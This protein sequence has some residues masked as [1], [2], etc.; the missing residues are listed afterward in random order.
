MNKELKPT[1]KLEIGLEKY[2][3]TTA[4]ACEI[5]A[6]HN[7]GKNRF[8]PA[9]IKEVIRERK[10]NYGS[11]LKDMS[12]ELTGEDDSLLIVKEDG[13]NVTYTIQEN[14][15]YDLVDIGEYEGEPGLFLKPIT[16]S[17]I[18]QKFNIA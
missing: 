7:E 2:G 4:K 8:T 3:L 9:Q 18:D 15:I 16:E 11:L 12:L 1:T 5:V 6:K 13:E 17:D 14:I 10:N